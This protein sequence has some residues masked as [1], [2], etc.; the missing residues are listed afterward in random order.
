MANKSRKKIRRDSK[1]RILR[2]GEQE[3][4]I[5]HRYSFSYLNV[6]GKRTYI[7]STSLIELREMEEQLK[8]DQHDGL[9]VYV[10]SKAT[11]NDAFDR[12]MSTKNNLRDNT[13]SGYLYVYD[14]CVRDDFGKRKLKDIRYSDVKRFYLYLIKEKG[15]SIAMVDSV[16]CLLHP[17]FTM[18]VRD[19]I[20]RINPADG[21]IGEVM[22][23][24]GLKTGVRHALTPEQQKAFMTYIKENPVFVHWWPTFAIIL[25]TGGRIGE[26]LGLTWDDV[27]L[28]KGIVSINHAVTY[29]QLPGTHTC[30]MHAHSTKT[31]AGVRY[32]PMV[33]KVKAAFELLKEEDEE[34]AG[35][36]Q[37]ID[38]YSDFV[39]RNRYG[40]VPNPASINR[41][42][43]RII[44]H[45]N[46]EEELKAAREKREPELLPDFSCHYLRHTFCTRLCERE[47]NLKVVQ[48]LMG[49]A[50]IQTTM[51]TYTEA[52][53][54]RNLE[55]V[56]SLDEVID[57]LL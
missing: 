28:D 12:Y 25:G 1:G 17:T 19:Q 45:Y 29:Y 16:Q 53:A 6:M 57:E 31:A 30:E 14:H 50:D 41:A 32:I 3:R 20:I 10:S 37:E 7:Y 34:I 15:Y 27:D 54:R 46:S 4:K 33:R 49:H 18:A 52:T 26:I 11:L 38:G 35:A 21:V 43:K 55:A 22:K 47:T 48:Y 44:G 40:K 51:N 36:D 42:I 56:E 13:K 8:V 39:F 5:D 9:N 24:T 2:K 23:D